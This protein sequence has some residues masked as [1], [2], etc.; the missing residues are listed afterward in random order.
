MRLKNKGL[1]CKKDSRPK[2][3]QP[4]KQSSQKR[5]RKAS[6]TNSSEKPQTWLGVKLTFAKPEVWVLL[7][8]VCLLAF[9]GE[10]GLLFALALLLLQ[11]LNSPSADK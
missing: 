8:I 9:R 2:S 11:R 10:A 6:L 5:E 7:A 3:I 1:S 4:A